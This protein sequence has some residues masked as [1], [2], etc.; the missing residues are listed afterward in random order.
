MP[1]S[2][3]SVFELAH[4]L[5][6]LI[7]V[8]R[9]WSKIRPSL[10]NKRSIPSLLCLKDQ[11]ELNVAVQTDQDAILGLFRLLSPGR[12]T[13]NKKAPE[14]VEITS[15]TAHPNKPLNIDFR[16]VSGIPLQPR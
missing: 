4:S 14:E 16:C 9:V 6:D 1:L 5:P 13:R 12:H 15:V 10:V 7:K 8:T 3:S 2:Q 11:P